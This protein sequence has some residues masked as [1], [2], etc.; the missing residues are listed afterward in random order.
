MTEAIRMSSTVGV[1]MGGAMVAVAGVA[2]GL[3]HGVVR[4]AAVGSN[5]SQLALPGMNDDQASTAY[6][7]AGDPS[8]V[9]SAHAGR[10]LDDS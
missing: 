5:I 8:E 2:A 6:L 3:A 1:A 9:Q 4:G 7:S 10:L